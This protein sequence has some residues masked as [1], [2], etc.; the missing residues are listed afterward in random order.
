MRLEPWAG[1]FHSLLL[2]PG[3]EV[4][5]ARGSGRHVQELGSHLF[6]PGGVPPEK[7]GWSVTPPVPAPDCKCS[8]LP[9]RP[10]P[11]GSGLVLASNPCMSLL[12]QGAFSDCTQK[13]GPALAFA[14]HRE[15]VA[16]HL[17][18][19]LVLPPPRH[20]LRPVHAGYI[21]SAQ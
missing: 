4:V 2:C 14:S 21:V 16:P 6:A 1:V 9:A 15:L 19:C 8:L 3:G 10:R 17:N 5:S 18:G 12:F 13:A 11:L 7:E 20:L